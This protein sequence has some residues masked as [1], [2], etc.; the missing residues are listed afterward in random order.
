[1]LAILDVLT[2]VDSRKDGDFWR[3]QTY[4]D[5]PAVERPPS[6]LDL[7]DSGPGSLKGKRIAVP[8]MF[9]GGQDRKA[10]P[11]DIS[12]DVINLWKQAKSDLESAGATVVETDFPL[13]SNYEDDSISGIA[14]NVVGI[15]PEWNIKE[16][17]ELVAYLW[18]DFLK[19]NGDPNCPSLANVD[20]TNIFPRPLGYIPDKYMEVKNMMNYPGVVEFA[21]N[22]NGKGIWEIEG[23]AEALPAL[24]A[25]R[26]RDLED[27]MKQKSIDLVVFP[28]CGDVGRADV[29][30]NDE[31]ARHALQNGVR[32]ST[33]NRAIRHMGV[34]TC[35]VSMGV[36]KN[37][38]MPVNLTFV[39][40]HGS[41][42][43]ILKY[44]YDFEQRTKRRIE[45]PVTPALKLD[46]V[47]AE[48]R[49]ISGE[50]PTIEVNSAERVSVNE[51]ELTGLVNGSSS[52]TQLEVRI[53][54]QSIPSSQIEVTEGRWSFKAK[55]K[56]FVPPQAL[57]G[58]Y[59]EVVGNVVIVLLARCSGQ[60]AGKLVLVSQTDVR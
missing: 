29:D 25:Q 10:K 16:R 46:K 38:K 49:E 50:T 35:S 18:D 5:I 24:E 59:G 6:F 53:N 30:I 44:T 34:P 2:V 33:G 39:G 3:E 17:G 26:K 41:D 60:V 21:R 56:H 12:Q 52:E 54:G 40:K 31:S 51:V 36:M 27:W 11:F 1:M 55:F 7:K 14:N 45:P 42:V 15:K 57:Y 23:I 19:A 47:H 20:G 37:T 58:G 22:R 8:S 28:A 13:V 32:Y 43:E 9:I 48:K 4:V